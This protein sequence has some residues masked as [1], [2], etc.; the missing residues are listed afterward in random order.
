MNVETR[1]SR[2]PTLKFM[3]SSLFKI[4]RMR[5]KGKARMLGQRDRLNADKSVI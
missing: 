3:V 4:I 2:L 1:W 5:L